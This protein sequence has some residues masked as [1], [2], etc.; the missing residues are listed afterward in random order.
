VRLVEPCTH[1]PE[2]CELPTELQPFHELPPLMSTTCADA[3]PARAS[4]AVRESDAMVDAVF[5]GGASE[6]GS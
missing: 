5:M 3:A 2:V 1:V 4:E 6:V